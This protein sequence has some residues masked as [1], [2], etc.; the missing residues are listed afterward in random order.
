MA[1]L[2]NA[3]SIADQ[4]MNVYFQ[5]PTSVNILLIQNLGQ[6]YGNNS[7]LHFES[8]VFVGAQSIIE[9]LTSLNVTII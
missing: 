1:E 9:K 2:Q 4:F 8:E 3:Q 6:Y 5:T 7:Y